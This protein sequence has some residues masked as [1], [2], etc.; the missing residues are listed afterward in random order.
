[1]TTPGRP[2]GLRYMPI[3]SMSCDIAAHAMN[4]LVRMCVAALCIDAGVG[5]VVAHAQAPAAAS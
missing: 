3:R 4:V 1:M 2:E 5:P